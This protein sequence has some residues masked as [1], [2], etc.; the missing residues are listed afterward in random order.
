MEK[1]I[2]IEELL[3]SFFEHTFSNAHICILHARRKNFSNKILIEWN[4]SNMFFF[5]P[6]SNIFVELA[7]VHYTSP[8]DISRNLF[9]K[10]SELPTE[11]KKVLRKLF[12][13]AI[14][15][16]FEQINSSRVVETAFCPVQKVVS[17][18]RKIPKTSKS[19]IFS[20]VWANTF[21][22][23]FCILLRVASR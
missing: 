12:Q 5:R 15:A 18:T 20:K 14:F 21:R 13:V 4:Y 22:P 3:F 7:N 8:Q 16:Y 19:Y 17:K 1:L 11:E 6:W 23:V 9:W 10:V 2:P